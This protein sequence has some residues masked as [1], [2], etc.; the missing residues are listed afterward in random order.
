MGLLPAG[1]LGLVT[2]FCCFGVGLDGLL[3]YGLP[4]VFLF[5]FCSGVCGGLPGAC[6]G[7]LGD[8]G[9]LLT[10]FISKEGISSGNLMGS[11]WLHGLFL[12][13]GWISL[14]LLFR[15]MS[16]SPKLTF[17]DVWKLLCFLISY[18]IFSTAEYLL[19]EKLYIGKLK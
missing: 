6:P 7:D 4:L 10:R 3:L 15:I 18:A 2:I 17:V 14:G 9:T 5:S 16:F 13:P 11:I 8:W 1:W 19:K 12:P